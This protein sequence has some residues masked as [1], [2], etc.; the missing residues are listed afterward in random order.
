MSE[1]QSHPG[2]QP[3]GGAFGPFAPQKFS[4]HCT[5]ILTFIETFK[6]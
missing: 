4:K 5:A 6:E 1:L 3:G 2:T